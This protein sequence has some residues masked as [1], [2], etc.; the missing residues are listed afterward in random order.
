M[1]L[2]ITPNPSLDFLFEA[3]QL[4]W[5]DANRVDA[6]RR[7]LGGQGINVTR[8]VRELGGSSTAVALLG[9]P[10]G[11]QIE[12]LL[13][14][15]GTPYQRIVIQNETRL[16]VGAREH[17]TGRSLLLNP[18]GPQI[19]APEA[20]RIVHELERMVASQQ[21]VWVAACGSIPP[22]LPVD[23][24]QRVGQWARAA[25]ANFVVDCDGD[26]LQA[27]APLAQLLVPNQHEA[28]R[29]VGHSIDD[30]VSL[31]KALRGLLA[32][33]CDTAAITLGARGAAV[34]N[35]QRAWLCTP[36]ELKTGS[37]VGAGDAFLAALLVGVCDA[38]PMDS[39]IRR[40]VAAGSAV[41]LGTGAQLLDPQH[42]ID[43]VSKTKVRPLD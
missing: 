32:L 36:P 42:A 7:R 22:G 1:I 2:T 34:A 14:A 8:A 39:C 17:L 10:I 38:A 12:H 41:L 24:Y 4:V 3:D 25:G 27:A 31:R 28:E 18:R 40:A 11:D 9:G 26:A 16:F 19:S 15:E 33:G 35:S 5:D 21:P 29:L 13:A 20:D 30:D 23:L 37:A 43:L 6:P